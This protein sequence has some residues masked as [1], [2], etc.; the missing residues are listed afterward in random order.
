MNA[1]QLQNAWLNAQPGE[2][3]ELDQDIGR[4]TLKK[5]KRAKG[6]PQVTIKLNGKVISR[7][8]E[9]GS[10]DTLLLKSG[11]RDLIIDGQGALL[12]AASRSGIKTEGP[13]GAR[14][15]WL[16]DMTVNGGWNVTGNSKPPPNKWLAHHYLTGSWIES[17]MVYTGCA[18][19]HA[20]YFHNIQG[21]QF[22]SGNLI[23]WCGRT[24]LQIVNRVKEVDTMMPQGY[25]DVTVENEEVV[26]VC[27]EQGGGG[28][29]YTF[30]GGMPS[31]TITM[32][33]VSVRLGCDAALHKD[34]Q[35]RATGALLMDSGPESN[36]GAGDMAWP[37]GTAALRCYDQDYEVGTVYPGVGSAKRPCVKVGAVKLFT[38]TD[39]R[40]KVPAGETALEI[41]HSC[42]TFMW[43]GK[44]EVVGKVRYKGQLYDEWDD[45]TSAHPECSMAAGS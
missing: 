1:T 26:D 13:G 9:V 41:Q 27:L 4:V 22:F 39:G 24:A 18:D 42:E 45:F 23:S 36:P 14:K 6:S 3:I 15:V 32:K 31:S 25:G 34:L 29:A 21:N 44:P 10:S 11:V 12:L 28:S 19:E 5:S 2:T 7:D 20:R 40:I 30:R 8:P 43:S 37:G 16:K 35:G 38:W 33:R 17:G